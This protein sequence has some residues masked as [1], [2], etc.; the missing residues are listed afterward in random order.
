[1]VV[2]A[3][4]S[5]RVL[6]LVDAGEVQTVIIAKLDRLTRSVK[7]LCTLLERFE[8][9]RVALIS[10]AES[11]DTGSAAGRLVLNIMTAVSQMGARGN[12]RANARCAVPQARRVSAWATSRSAPGSRKTSTT[13]GRTRPS[14]QCLLRYGGCETKAPYA[15]HCGHVERAGFVRPQQASSHAGTFSQPLPSQHHRAPVRPTV[16]TLDGFGP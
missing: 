9:R 2:V 7:D 11:L 10:V 8:R 13:W 5:E 15:R 12:R 14:K 1:M 3:A 16:A 4:S 6:A